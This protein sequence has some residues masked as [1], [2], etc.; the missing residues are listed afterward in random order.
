MELTVY[1]FFMGNAG[2]MSSTVGSSIDF[3]SNAL[4]SPPLPVK[5][6]YVIGTLRGVRGEGVGDDT[7][8]NSAFWVLVTGSKAPHPPPVYPG[9]GPYDHSGPEIQSSRSL[10]AATSDS[11]PGEGLAGAGF[12]V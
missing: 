5:A 8:L 2:F 11:E 10:T 6:P 7:S 9:K 4:Q 3:F 12:R 1:S